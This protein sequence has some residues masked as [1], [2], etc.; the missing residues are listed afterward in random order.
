M[1]RL[2]RR[3]RKS[4]ECEH[5]YEG[6]GPHPGCAEFMDEP[7]LIPC[8]RKATRTVTIASR[9]VSHPKGKRQVDKYR[10]CTEHAV[11]CATYNA[12]EGKQWGVEVVLVRPLAG[13]AR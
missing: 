6:W 12:G 8:G 11:E 2:T 5:V 4:A 1:N 9:D 3:L 13:G 7:E 10:F